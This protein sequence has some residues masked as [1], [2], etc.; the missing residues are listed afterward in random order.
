MASVFD[1]NSVFI[2]YF[3]TGIMIFFGN[4]RQSGQSVKLGNKI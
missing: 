3:R 4:L 2:I 1:L